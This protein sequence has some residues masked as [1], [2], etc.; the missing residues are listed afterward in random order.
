MYNT[1]EFYPYKKFDVNGE[2]FL[3]SATNTGIFKINDKVEKMIRMHGA[4][5]DQ[6]SIELN[7]TCTMEELK[8]CLSAMEKE[9]FLKT[10]ENDIKIE[11]RLNPDID[12][13]IMSVTLM[14]IQECN[15]RCKYCYAE[16]GQYHDKGKMNLTT[17]K[18]SIDFLI[19]SAGDIGELQVSL[20]GGEPLIMMPLIKNIVNYIKLKEQETKKKIHIGMTTNGTLI[21]EE[22]EQFMI[23]N[24]IHVQISIDG[25]KETHDSNR[26]FINK[27]GSYDKVVEKTR[28]M[29][30]KGL[31]TARGT[32][33]DE[34]LNILQSFYHLDLLGFRGIALAPAN[35]LL[36]EKND[37]KLLENQIEY[38]R[39]FE[40][41]VKNGKLNLARKMRMTLSMMEKIHNGN[42]RF[43]PCGV[44]RNAYAI[45]INGDIYP[46][47]R[48]VS[49]KEYKL[50][51][52]FD[53]SIGRD[54]FIEKV[55]ICNHKQCKDCWAKNLCLGNC[56]HENLMATGNIQESPER[57]C[58]MTRSMY[59][60]VIKVY[61]DLTEEEKEYLFP[62][63][64]KESK[65]DK[66]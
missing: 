47:H 44:G 25:N 61:L 38:I 63:E 28:S 13:K 58:N 40:T 11:K 46:C 53:V 31:L 14:L 35:N 10:E 32:I 30:E 65:D 17:A 39:E 43:L 62:N 20:F 29:R 54:Q 2:T 37:N 19:D 60:E 6:M 41:L 52:V 7:D 56:P 21:T 27:T 64:Y 12:Q 34:G 49:N 59:E 18:K 22:I 45:D 1:I 51:S 5:F 66:N 16:D 24:D 23:K 33:T 4:S 55:L 26:Y 42:I 57:I 36:S 50:G 48:F 3:Y 8:E 9:M 15:M